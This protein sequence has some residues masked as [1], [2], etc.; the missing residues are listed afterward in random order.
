MLSRLLLFL[1]LS[2]TLVSNAQKKVPFKTGSKITQAEAQSAL[3]F[4]N[5]ARKEVNVPALEWSAELSAY[6]QKWAEHLDSLGCALQH[7]PRSGVW[8]Q[9]YGENIFW[10]SGS[11]NATDA[12]KSWYSEKKDF[13]GPVFTG[14]ETSVVGHY[15]QMVWRDTKKVGI[16]VVKCKGGGMIIVANYDPAGNYRGE[17][18]Y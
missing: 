11:Y 8:V 3:D 17:A 18:A 2:G 14:E 7:R 10:G 16:G 6:A 9:Q 4:H 15:T 5:K 13:V 12:C 1:L